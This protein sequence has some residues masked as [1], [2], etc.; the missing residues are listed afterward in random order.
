MDCSINAR[1]ERSSISVNL[2]GNLVCFE[3]NQFNSGCCRT[4]IPT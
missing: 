1:I 2:I 3:R 4:V